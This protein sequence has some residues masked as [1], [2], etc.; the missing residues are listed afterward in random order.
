MG[1]RVE[2]GDGGDRVTAGPVTYRVG[3]AGDEVDEARTTGG[4]GT[5]NYT[6]N[7]AFSP[8]QIKSLQFL[9]LATCM[10][11]L[12]LFSSASTPE[13]DQFR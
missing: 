8:V 5:C 1:K 12:F 3:L 10:L 2:S 9:A 4:L 7:A 6:I 13:K 11:D